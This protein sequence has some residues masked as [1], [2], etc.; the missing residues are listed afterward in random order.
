MP[1]V[2]TNMSQWKKSGIKKAQKN[3]I[4]INSKLKFSEK[5]FSR[6]ISEFLL[7]ETLFMF[8]NSQKKPHYDTFY[9]CNRCFQGKNVCPLQEVKQSVEQSI[10]SHTEIL[11]K[12]L[13]IKQ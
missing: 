13:F 9:H 5:T 10:H 12:F 2:T 6:N 1:A 7:L 4:Q 8:T 3:P 11:V